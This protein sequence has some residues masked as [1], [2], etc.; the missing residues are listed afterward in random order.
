[1]SLS[2]FVV[3]FDNIVS[4]A[5]FPPSMSDGVVSVRCT[6]I[7]EELFAAAADISTETVGL[8][9]DDSMDACALLIGMK[10]LFGNSVREAEA[11]DSSSD[12]REHMSS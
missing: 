2:S 1:M 11:M 4:R 8:E 6:C 9:S 10:L 3:K 12:C 5:A 7:I